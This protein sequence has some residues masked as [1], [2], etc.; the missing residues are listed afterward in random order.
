MEEEKQREGGG[1]GEGER[2]GG[3]GEGG[4]ERG[5]GEGGGGGGIGRNKGECVRVRWRSS[6]IVYFI[7]YTLNYTHTQHLTVSSHVN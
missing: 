2:E 6:I 3:R 1:R 5:R 7:V 4:R